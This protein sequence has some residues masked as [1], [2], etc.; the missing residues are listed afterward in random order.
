M[1]S[2]NDS[3]HN[4]FTLI[5]ILKNQGTVIFAPLVRVWASG[6]TTLSPTILRTVSE[7]FFSI[8]ISVF[9]QWAILF[10][11]FGLI[12]AGTCS[13]AQLTSLMNHLCRDYVSIALS[14]GLSFV[15]LFARP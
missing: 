9:Q 4:Y 2:D 8:P 7:Q 15:A 6:D 13:A 14:A 10:C 3:V 1:M 11:D 12:K 5:L